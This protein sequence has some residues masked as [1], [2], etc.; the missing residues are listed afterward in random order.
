MTKKAY[1][2]EATGQTYPLF[3]ADANKV[4]NVFRTDVEKADRDPTKQVLLRA[5]TKTR[6]LKA[7]SVKL[8]RKRVEGD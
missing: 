7:R 3:E 8:L 1:K 2:V 4:F 5:P 6:T